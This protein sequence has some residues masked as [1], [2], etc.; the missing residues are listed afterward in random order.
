MLKD[1]TNA[2]KKLNELQSKT[3]KKYTKQIP[4]LRIIALE[5]FGET[6]KAKSELAKLKK[7][8][9]TLYAAAFNSNKTQQP[10]LIEIFPCDKRLNERFAPVSLR[11]AAGLLAG[12]N[13]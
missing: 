7:T 1:R 9:P 11:F 3:P 4:L 13:F 6:E 2:L 8:D 10:F 12:T 5:H